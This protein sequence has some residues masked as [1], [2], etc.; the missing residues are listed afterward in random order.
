MKRVGH[1]YEQIAD[2]ENL[3]LAFWKAQRGKSGKRDVVAFRDHLDAELSAL[4]AD[5]ISESVSVGDY[6][7]FTIH[8]PKERLICAA[9]FRERVLH[10]AI[11]N[12][13]EP[14]F[15][16]FQIHNSYACRKGKGTYK[17]LDRARTFSHRHRFYLKLDIR[18]YFYCVDH[19]VLKQQLRCR[20]KDRPL[21]GLL[22]QIIESYEVSSGKGIPIGN[23]TSQYFANHYLGVLDHFVKEN[24]RCKAY[25][26]YMDDF[27]L[28]DDDPSEL[29]AL[30]VQIERFLSDG[31]QLT[32]K[33]PA[34]NRTERGLSMLGYR[35]FPDRMLLTRRSRD[36]FSAKLKTIER[37]LHSGEWT[38]NE[39]AMHVEPL[40]AF[41]RQADT[42][43]FRKNSGAIQ[44]SNRVNRGGSWNNNASN[45]R[46]ANRNNNSPDNTNNNLGFRPI[47]QQPVDSAAEQEGIPFPLA[48]Q[49]RNG[50]PGAGSGAQMRA[51]NVPGRVSRV[52][53]SLGS[54]PSPGSGLCFQRSRVETAEN[55]RGCPP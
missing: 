27:V 18:K 28:W 55:R 54:L 45:C 24:L 48:G 3:R 2:P 12:I 42:H 50:P 51:A 25:V 20:L 32:L 37:N 36:R 19:A 52:C 34:L 23:L 7:Y 29:K 33:P 8:D 53:H 35:V 14:V 43:G 9:P 15:E 39:A 21:L 16:K 31:L 49:K 6:R 38:E 47:A 10:H 4:R 22:D 41:V 30:L 11:I 44:G 13:T 26:R 17:A 1:L 40:L 46:S 5:L